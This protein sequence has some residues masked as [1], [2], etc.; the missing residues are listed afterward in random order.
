MNQGRIWC[1]VNPTVGLPLFLGGV[2]TISLLVHAS[3]MT[4]TTWMANYW[5]GSARPR[6]ADAGG[7]P[8]VAAQQATP[9]FAI[10]VAPAS[11]APGETSFVVTVTPAGGTPQAAR[12]TPQPEGGTGP[13]ALAAPPDRPDR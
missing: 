12:V 13:L 5:Q 3:V 9:G 2:A 4:N 11:A 10:T 1:V 7:A 8:Q 6:A